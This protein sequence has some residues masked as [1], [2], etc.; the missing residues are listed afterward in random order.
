MGY[1]ITIT[2]NY[3]IIHFKKIKLLFMIETPNNKEI[4]SRSPYAFLINPKSTLSRHTASWKN[5]YSPLG[6][7]QGTA[8]TI[9]GPHHP[10]QH[11]SINV[12]TEA[13]RL[14]KM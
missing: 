1:I 3:M 6:Q 5:G 8:A 7:R 10:A 2:K 14:E 9:S 13:F 12:E 11:S 4:D